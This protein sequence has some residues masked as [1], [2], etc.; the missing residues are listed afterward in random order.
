[1]R[2]RWPFNDENGPD[3]AFAI[4][5]ALLISAAAAYFGF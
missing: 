3:V 2:R 4:I 5:V 1:M